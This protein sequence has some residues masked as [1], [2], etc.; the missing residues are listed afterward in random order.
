MADGFD[1]L[2]NE[3]REID[4]LAAR[5]EREHDDTT[6]YDVCERITIHAHIEEAALYPE[7]RRLVDGGDD[8]ADRAEQE[9]SV[10]K[11][12]IAQVYGSPPEELVHLMQRLAEQTR[13]HVD[14]EES[15]LFPQMLESGVDAL[16][17]GDAL[18][19]ARAA[20]PA[21]TVRSRRSS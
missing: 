4:D 18:E 21:E 8:L 2:R 5:Y 11:T 16:A 9:H 3:H 17:L 19:K 7:L 15:E 12:L 20:I 10:L 13:E 6:A 1:T 14:A